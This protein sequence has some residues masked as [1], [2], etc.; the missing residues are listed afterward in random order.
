MWIDQLKKLLG[1]NYHP[2]NIIEISRKNLISNYRKLSSLTKNIKVAPVFKSNAYGHGL[3]LTAKILD[4]LHPPFFC[5]DSLSEAY[6]LYK[7]GIKTPVLIIG[8][9]NPENLSIKKLPFSYAVYSYAQ[10]KTLLKY[11]PKAEI[12]LFIDIGMHREGISH[13]KINDFLTKLKD[14]ERKRITGVMSH[15]AQS[16]RPNSQETR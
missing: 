15:F 6:E 12:H 5:V 3:V 1:R 16:N 2:L 13:D 14:E 11:Q 7:I 9:V 8:Y 10:L 4:P